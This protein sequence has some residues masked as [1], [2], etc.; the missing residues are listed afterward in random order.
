MLARSATAQRL[1]IDGLTAVR[2]TRDKPKAPR[3]STLAIAGLAQSPRFFRDTSTCRLKI[4]FGKGY[5]LPWNTSRLTN[6]PRL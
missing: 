2:S 4:S 1:G 3:S 6:V 5:L